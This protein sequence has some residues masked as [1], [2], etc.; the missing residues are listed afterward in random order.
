MNQR[1]FTVRQLTIND[2][3][4]VKQ[5]HTEMQDDYVL[6]I[7]PHLVQSETQALFGWF[8][9]NHL[10]SIAGY[11]LFPGGYA[12]L[13]RLRSDQRFRKKGHAANLLSHMV[14][15]LVRDPNVR[16][17]GANTNIHNSAAKKVIEKLGLDEITS[18]YSFPVK[19]NA[20]VKGTD[21]EIWR[22][23]TSSSDKRT[24]LKRLKKENALNVYP[25]EC[26][27]PLPYTDTLITDEE[28]E[29]S[30][31]FLNPT[32][33]RFLIIKNDQKRERFAQIKYFWN[34][35]F[36]QA[37]FW[38]TVNHQV[39]NDCLSPRP[40]LDFSEEGLANIPNIKLFDVS[41]GWILYGRWVKKA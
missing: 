21:G 3:V 12:M 24:L 15:M 26:Y 35:H 32:N 8:V 27:Y 14:D 34:D 13:G 37:G 38:N 18:L 7:F 25:F 39:K 6:H 33:D 28:L 20:F 30:Y 36:E 23:I 10:A 2:H 1:L 19:P 17:I 31:F 41:D 16:W 40:W 11:T 29:Q 9:N 5:M 22:K 4:L